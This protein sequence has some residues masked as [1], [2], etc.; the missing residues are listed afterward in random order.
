MMGTLDFELNVCI[1]S[2]AFWN[3]AENVLFNNTRQNSC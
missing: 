2:A 3:K 1:K